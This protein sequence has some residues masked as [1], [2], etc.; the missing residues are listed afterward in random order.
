M[1]MKIEMEIYKDMKAMLILSITGTILVSAILSLENILLSL[2][3]DIEGCSF[4][5]Q[6]YM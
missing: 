6:S 2:Y 4:S 5:E 3:F 1:V